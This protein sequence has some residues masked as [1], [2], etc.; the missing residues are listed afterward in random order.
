MWT[1]P[2]RP[3][4]S[5]IRHQ[6]A[7]E[8]PTMDVDKSVSTITM[9]GSSEIFATV[10]QSQ[11]TTLYFWDMGTSK[12]NTIIL[13]SNEIKQTL[14]HPENPHVMIVTTKG[15]DAIFYVLKDD[16]SSPT[17]IRFAVEGPPA[18]QWEG[19]WMMP[20]RMGRGSEDMAGPEALEPMGG[21]LFLF[22]N[23]RAFDIGAIEDSPEGLGY[24]SVVRG[25][26]E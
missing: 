21:P 2:T 16:G 25:L 13:F 8:G 5:F 9:T 3:A 26:S 23:R 14:E 4:T 17:M 7:F 11:K 15:S 6:T 10:L 20:R 18:G 22:S 19:S 12:L 24:R 1:E